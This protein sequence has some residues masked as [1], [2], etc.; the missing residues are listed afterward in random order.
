MIT[1]EID[2]LHSRHNETIVLIKLSSYLRFVRVRPQIACFQH[3]ARVGYET[4]NNRPTSHFISVSVSVYE[5]QSFISVSASVYE[6]QKVKFYFCVRQ[7][8]RETERERIDVV[9]YVTNC[10]RF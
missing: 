6:R 5:R 1:S 7:C 8:L 2:M 10:H 3:L 4:E 9:K